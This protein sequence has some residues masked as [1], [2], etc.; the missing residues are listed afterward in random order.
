MKFL[1]VIDL[2]LTFERE[3]CSKRD[4]IS[5]N[6]SLNKL[7]VQLTNKQQNVGRF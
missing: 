4:I 3:Q 1:S 5:D 7:T 6:F 2:R